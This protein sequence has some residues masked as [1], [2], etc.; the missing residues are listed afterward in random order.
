MAEPLAF[1]TLDV[2]TDRAFGGNPLA[3]VLGA[4]AL[5]TRTMQQIA[6]EFN[7]SETV[8][9]LAPDNEAHSARVRIF[10]PVSELPF[11]GHPTVGT[12][13]LLA[14]LQAAKSTGDSNALVILEEQ[15]GN[16][17][18]GVSLFEKKP[19]FA[20][21]DVPVLP[22]EYADPPGHNDMAIALGL[23]TSEV[24]FAN[25]RV[26]C[27]GAGIHFVFVPV[28]SR[29]VL[30]EATPNIAYWQ[31]VREKTGSGSVFLYTPQTERHDTR[32]RARMFAPQD[33]IS[34]DPATG[35]AAAAFA[36]V[37]R[38]FDT[39]P[40]GHHICR[41]EQGDDMG[42]PSLI[43]LTFDIV[44]GALSVV[45]IGGNAIRICHGHI[46]PAFKD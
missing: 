39:P 21:F 10:T 34:E 26:T 36:G 46:T 42:R 40:D 33:G 22:I 25:H 20:E 45:R 6:R 3:V 7:L 15:I 24:G 2:F 35:S 11:A 28:A 16:V 32:F 31:A 23:D 29:R 5:D 12:A 27:F 1:H 41:L 43:T 30:A 8:F 4:D 9:V 18:A 44:E 14:Q 38:K 37:I 19:A 17:R 13:V